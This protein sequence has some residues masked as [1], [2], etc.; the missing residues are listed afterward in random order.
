MNKKLLKF[1]VAVSILIAVTIWINNLSAL[2]ASWCRGI[3]FCDAVEQACLDGE[4]FYEWKIGTFCYSW[5]ICRTQFAVYC[6]DEDEGEFYT[7]GAY[8]DTPTQIG[9][10]CDNY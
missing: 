3:D 2:P 4:F 9:D 7:R 5:Y 1:A 6:F 10:Q 8:C